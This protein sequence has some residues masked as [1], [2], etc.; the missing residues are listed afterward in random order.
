MPQSGQT[1]E[2]TSD[3]FPLGHLLNGESDSFRGESFSDAVDDA[4]IADG[5]GGDDDEGS[6][7]DLGGFFIERSSASSCISC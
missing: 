6:D 2:S 3:V 5:E 4:A 1:C 7:G